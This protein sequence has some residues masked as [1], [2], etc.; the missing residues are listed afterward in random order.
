MHD[1]VDEILMRHHGAASRGQLLAVL[2]RSRLDHEVARG[3]L[4]APFPRAYCRPWDAD[5]PRIRQ[6]AALASVG[7]P[8]ALSHVTALQR[9]ELLAPFS[10]RVHVTVPIGR[11]PIGRAPGLVVHRTRVP[12]RTQAVGGLRIVA[13]EFAVVRSWPMIVGLDQRAPAIL[14]VRKRLVTPATL[15]E[16]ATSAVGMP[17]RGALLRLVA[18]LA[19]GC[20]SDLELWGHLHVF[21]VPELRHAVRQKLVQVQGE[22]YRL[23]LAYSAEQVA[24]ELDGYRYHSTRAQRERDMR[25]DAALASIDWLTL[26][27]SHERLHDDIAGCRRD[28]LAALAARRAW[29]RSA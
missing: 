13:P 1:A 25:R 5:I 4:V 16:T 7:P 14:A 19:A 6:A 23:D 21:D 28:T 26:R 20:E 11:H 3:E 22:W 12:T 15:R 27:F 29:R 2:T 10:D 9:W 8:A 24:V 17:G 18:L